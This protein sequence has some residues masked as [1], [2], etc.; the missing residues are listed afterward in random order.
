MSAAELSDIERRVGA[1]I[2]KQPDSLRTRLRT[3]AQAPLGFAA[4]YHG[5]T[6]TVARVRRESIPAARLRYPGIDALAAALAGDRA[7]A[8][9]WLTRAAADTTFPWPG[10]RFTAGQAAQLLGRPAEALRFHQSVDNA[11]FTVI[12][13]LDHD[14]IIFGRS[15]KG[16]GDAALALGDTASARRHYTRVVRLWKDADA[17]FRPE[18]DAAAAALASLDRGDVPQVRVIPR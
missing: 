13:E 18:R 1:F 6:A 11:A 7:G 10:S 17:Q 12:G 2:A 3:N 4:A 9:R 16:R 15:L 14:W 5:D 8:E